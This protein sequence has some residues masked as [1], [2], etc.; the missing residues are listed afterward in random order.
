M[1]KFSWTFRGTWTTPAIFFI[2][3]FG[4]LFDGL[5]TYYIISIG[6]EGGVGGLA[7]Y[8][9]LIKSGK[10]IILLDQKLWIS[11]LPTVILKMVLTDPQYQQNFSNT[12][13]TEWHDE[14]FK[15]LQILLGYL[16]WLRTQMKNSFNSIL[17]SV[18]LD[19]RTNNFVRRSSN[20]LK[21]KINYNRPSKSKEADCCLYF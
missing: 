18:L 17:S 1:V 3:I 13:E 15:I 14:Y 9:K 21:E 8:Q 4:S 16:L 19:F 11:N 10:G 12:Q 2:L 20:N 7:K 6:R 5:A